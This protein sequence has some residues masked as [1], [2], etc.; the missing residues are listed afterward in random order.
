MTAMAGM[1]AMRRIE[2]ST[3]KIVRSFER[4]GT[5][6]PGVDVGCEDEFVTW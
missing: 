2:I 1:A 5:D 6:A 3:I 4:D